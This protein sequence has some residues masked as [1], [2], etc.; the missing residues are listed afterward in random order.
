MITADLTLEMNSSTVAEVALAIPQ[1]IEILN[2]YNL[3]YCCHGDVPFT[4][5]CIS[6]QLD[7]ATVW[8]AIMKK[9]SGPVRVNRMDFSS[10]NSSVLADFIVQHHHTYIREAIP[11]INE[12]LDKICEVHGDKN[13]ELLAIRN[14][15]L[16]LADDLLNHL[17]KE[18]EIL[19]PAIKRMEG[20]GFNEMEKVILPSA[21][22]APMTIMESEHE[23]AGDLIK[24]IRAR[25]NNYTPPSYACPTYQLT[26]TMLKEFDDDLI[27]HI[28]LENN[29]LF[30][31]VRKDS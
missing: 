12:L 23:R 5:A 8:S 1:A 17:P 30:P 20:I 3:D 9:T 11:Q 6:L 24:L 31:R 22:K 19:F 10:W 21:L 15:F 27:Q 14:D 7:P 13:P 25:T 29:I 4:Q 28:H 2:Q 26:F 18:E 16:E